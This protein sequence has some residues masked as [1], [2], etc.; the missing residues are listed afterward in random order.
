MS[1]VE[2]TKTDVDVIKAANDAALIGSYIKLRNQK[3]AIKAVAEEQTSKINALMGI[4]ES[5]LSER[6][7]ARKAKSVATAN[8]TA[9][10]VTKTSATI[11][12][13][14]AFREFVLKEQA[15][16]V[17]DWRANAPGVVA[18]AEK[19]EAAPP[20]LNVSSITLVQVRK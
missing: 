11:A 14:P 18:Y 1:N 16:D 3:K 10:Q 2:Q 12:D 20:G 8:G 5:Q 9:F 19:H 6:L 15:W 7:V 17:V 13:L 4:I